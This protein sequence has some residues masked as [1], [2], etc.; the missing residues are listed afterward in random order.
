MHYRSNFKN[1]CTYRTDFIL[2]LRDSNVTIFLDFYIE[3]DLY[4][5]IDYKCIGVR[6]KGYRRQTCL[7]QAKLAELTEMSD[8]YISRIETGAKKAS[9]GSLAKIASVL[10]I[11]LD[12]LVFGE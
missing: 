12:V 5:V 10:E 2:L 7:T 9:L 8:T 1:L 3:E 4:M 6:L 11:S